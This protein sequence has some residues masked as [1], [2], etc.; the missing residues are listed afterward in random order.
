M[1]RIISQLGQEG[2]GPRDLVDIHVSA[3]DQVSEDGSSVRARTLALEGRL[4]A[5]EM[6]GLLVDYYR[7]RKGAGIR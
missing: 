7:V 4:V 6:M 2:A 3:L 1:N 5:L